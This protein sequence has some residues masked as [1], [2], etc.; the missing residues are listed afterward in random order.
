MF[1][2][3][4][5]YENFK[6][7]PLSMMSKSLPSDLSV[8][9]SSPKKPDSSLLIAWRFHPLFVI[10]LLRESIDIL[11]PDCSM[12]ES[13]ISVNFGEYTVTRFTLEIEQQSLARTIF[14][15]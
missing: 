12:D 9:I 3:T 7:S 6:L 10:E 14:T 4:S 13:L 8:K 1:D 15:S 11:V 2:P 5:L